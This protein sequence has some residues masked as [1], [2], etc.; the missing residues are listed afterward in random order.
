MEKNNN[1]KIKM[2]QKMKRKR[3]KMRIIIKNQ[4]KIIRKKI[5][6]VKSAV[7]HNS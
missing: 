5:S 3:K 7:N 1:S 4:K 6:Y 2:N